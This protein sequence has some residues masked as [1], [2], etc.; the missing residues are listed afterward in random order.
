MP[1]LNKDH[2]RLRGEH[3]H[4]LAQRGRRK[5]SSPPAR[6]AHRDHRMSDTEIRIIPA[7]AGSTFQ[8]ESTRT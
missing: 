7:C 8:P 5:G 3:S 4:R 1:R 6:G 2:P